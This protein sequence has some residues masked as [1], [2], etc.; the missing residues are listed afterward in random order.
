[1]PPGKRRMGKVETPKWCL[2]RNRGRG[3]V[4][5]LAGRRIDSEDALVRRFPLQNAGMVSARIDTCFLRENPIAVVC[6]A[7]CG[8]DLIAVEVAARHNIRCRLVL[9]LPIAQFRARSVA[10]RPGNWTPLFNR[11]CARARRRNDLVLLSS[12][13]SEASFAKANE[14]ILDEAMS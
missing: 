14:G 7:A 4:I 8:A 11:A 10:D 1:M 12:G 9:P 3:V 6:S 2:G 13:E 5:A